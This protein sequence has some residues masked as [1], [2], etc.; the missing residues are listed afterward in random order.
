MPSEKL[1]HVVMSLGSQGTL[2]GFRSGEWA[3]MGQGEEAGSRNRK[4]GLPVAFTAILALQLSILEAT[5]L[6]IS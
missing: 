2:E 6:V 3:P 4:Q 1:P 5:L